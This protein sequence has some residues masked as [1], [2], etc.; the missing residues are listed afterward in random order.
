VVPV[1]QGRFRIVQPDVVLEDIRRQAAAGAEHI[2]FGDPDFFNGPAHAVRIVEALHAEFPALT[3][4]VTI[5]VEHLL[6]RRDLLRLLR[7]TG[8]LFVTTAVESLE[9][10][11]LERLDKGHTRRD[12]LE[13]A[14]ACR[15][16]GLTLAPTFVPFTPWTSWAGYRDLLRLLVELQIVDHVSPVQLG[17]RLLI[18]AGSRLLEFEDLRQDLG[19]FD[20]AA[21][22]YPWRH[23]DPALDELS[24][25]VLSLAAKGQQEKAS[26]REIFRG[27]W[28]LAD[29]GPL[30]ENFDLMP[31]ATVP[32][33]DEPWYC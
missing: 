10:A 25:A 33:L 11:V 31:R 27:I 2:T 28:G 12:F 26:R 5:K 18:P 19:P 20:D 14:E 23:S 21:L 22:V 9:F 32:Y 8:C 6:G 13:V 1:Y 16:A 4:D 3:Y 29:A 17:L 30:P 24:A 7:A 15:A